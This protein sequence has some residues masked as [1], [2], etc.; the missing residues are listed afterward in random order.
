MITKH[1]RYDY[2][3]WRIYFFIFFEEP[4]PEPEKAT[5]NVPRDES[6]L[7]LQIL[8]SITLLQ[9]FTSNEANKV[10]KDR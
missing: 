7:P 1:R 8:C 9:N 5:V 6:I 10:L 3:K 2:L 4:E